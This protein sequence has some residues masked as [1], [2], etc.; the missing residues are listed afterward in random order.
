MNNIIISSDKDG[1]YI[2]NSEN[3]SYKGRSR[4]GLV[5]HMKIFHQSKNVK[6]EYKARNYIQ[7]LSSEEEAMIDAA[8]KVENDGRHICV[9]SP[10]CSFT[11]VSKSGTVRH[12]KVVHLNLATYSCKLC[13]Y[14]TKFSQSLADHVSSMHE[15]IKH[16]CKFC[17]FSLTHKGSV[18]LHMRKKHTKG[19]S[20]KCKDCDYETYT[21][22]M[23]E[24]H[25]N[26][27]H[28]KKLLYCDKCE[29]QTTW[30]GNLRNHIA[31]KH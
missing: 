21:N 1:N 23:L 25:I 16:T 12:I 6:R 3:C 22:D 28:L 13:N 31:S 17:D 20:K 18:Y 14:V 27:R 9:M 5:S 11:S 30:G 10:G 29:Y 7:K 2:C 19:Y 4:P 15:K 26:G 24:C 8:I